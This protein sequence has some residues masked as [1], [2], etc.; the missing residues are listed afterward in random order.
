VAGARYGTGVASGTGSTAH[1]SQA[2][3]RDFSDTRSLRN[4]ISP[5][6]VRDDD[7]PAL[8]GETK[9][10][11]STRTGSSNSAGGRRETITGT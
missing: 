3:R 10:G 6:E 11:R 1:A 7:A 2:A 9:T 5:S 8:V 4:R